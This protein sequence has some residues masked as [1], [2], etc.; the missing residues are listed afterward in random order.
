MEVFKLNPRQ[1][2]KISKEITQKTLNRAASKQG[3]MIEE[4]LNINSTDIINNK[5]SCLYHL[6]EQQLNQLYE[7]ENVILQATEILKTQVNSSEFSDILMKYLESLELHI[8]RLDDLILHLGL[9]T[10]I[11]HCIGLQSIISEGEICMNRIL[12]KKLRDD[13]IF[14]VFRKISFYKMAS[15]INL[16]IMAQDLKYVKAYSFLKETLDEERSF[17][18]K[19]LNIALEENPYNYVG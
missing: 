19:I 13:A 15:Y 5:N 10:E 8:Q 17:H 7:E 6:F 2:M 11:I 3:G 12:D 14:A 1:K 4:L 18:H 9:R 16:Q